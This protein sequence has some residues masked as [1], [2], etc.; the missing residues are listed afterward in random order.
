MEIICIDYDSRLESQASEPLAALFLK[1][2]T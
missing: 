2:S 1:H